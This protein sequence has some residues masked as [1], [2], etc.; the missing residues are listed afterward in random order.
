[1]TTAAAHGNPEAKVFTED[2]DPRE[3][4]VVRVTRVDAQV[5]YE[6]ETPTG[7]TV[8]VQVNNRPLRTLSSRKS[9]T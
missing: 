9:A 6:V 8:I 5:D 2:V 1:V 4:K 7:E 3:G